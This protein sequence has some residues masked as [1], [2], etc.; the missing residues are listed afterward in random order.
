MTTRYF[1]DP[2]LL[3][4]ADMIKLGTLINNPVIDINDINVLSPDINYNGSL[5][6]SNSLSLV[7]NCVAY[8]NSG[9]FV[10]YTILDQDIDTNNFNN[11]GVKTEFTFSTQVIEV[12]F[13]YS[14]GDHLGLEDV[15]TTRHEL[16]VFSDVIS[17]EEKALKGGQ[18]STIGIG[19]ANSSS[20][21]QKHLLDE[22]LFVTNGAVYDKS[23]L[24][25]YLE[26]PDLP[27]IYPENVRVF[28]YNDKI[29]VATWNS[30][31]AKIFRLNG[32]T[33]LWET[34]RTETGTDIK[35]ITISKIRDGN[36]IKDFPSN[37][38]KTFDPS[39]VRVILDEYE[40]GMGLLLFD[41][42][43]VGKQGCL[44]DKLFER[45]DN[46]WAD[47]I[48]SDPNIELEEVVDVL[49]NILIIR[50]TNNDYYATNNFNWFKLSLTG[51]NPN[52]YKLEGLN[53]KQFIMETPSNIKLIFTLTE[54]TPPS[55]PFESVV[56]DYRSV[57]IPYMNTKVFKNW[58]TPFHVHRNLIFE[59]DGNTL[60]LI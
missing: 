44:S 54:K 48:D 2:Q 56:R 14:Y 33:Y 31:D 16:K 19:G 6:L 4:D 45:W 39:T 50:S 7:F 27:S 57:L 13:V 8:F 17:N 46:T 25:H 38:T 18:I 24:A 40:D 53:N 58:T 29:H 35:F 60:K 59:I 51:Y 23:D 20:W 26:I 42:T 21:I 12:D 5:F 1:T 43:K 52:T 22:E 49:G 11:F 10:G 3:V 55:T 47:S 34:E 41:K 30:T 37:K 15:H 28:L 36:T 32:S 9:V